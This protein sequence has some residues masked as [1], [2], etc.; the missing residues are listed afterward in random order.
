VI[1]QHR[2]N[3]PT[4]DRHQPVQLLPSDKEVIQ[5]PSRQG[6]QTKEEGQESGGEAGEDVH[7]WVMTVNNA[8]ATLC[9]WGRAHLAMKSVPLENT[10]SA[11]NT[12]IIALGNPYDQ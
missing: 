12:T 5:A 6:K 4:V 10:K 7:T 2:L 11:P 1:N 3:C 9:S 8:P